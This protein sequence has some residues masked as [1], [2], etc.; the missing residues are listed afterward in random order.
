MVAITENTRIWIVLEELNKLGYI[1]EKFIEEIK[2]EF[3]KGCLRKTIREF[4]FMDHR[5]R[6]E[7]SYSL[8]IK[9]NKLLKSMETLCG[10][11]ITNPYNHFKKKQS[12][13]RL[14][15]AKI[16]D[17]LKFLQ[18]LEETKYKYKDNLRDS[19]I[20]ML[21][22]GLRTSEACRLKYSDVNKELSE[23]KIRA[24]K[25]DPAGRLLSF[26]GILPHFKKEA[27]SILLRSNK[28]EYIIF[29]DTDKI[30][31]STICH[32]LTG[33]LK[34]INKALETKIKIF[35]L[36]DLRSTYASLMFKEGAH[37]NAIANFMGHKLT[38]TTEKHYA[39]DYFEQIKINNVT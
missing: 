21:S 1:N 16:E 25:N 23:L 35:E 4:K 24:T 34:K 38:T 17:I 26:G 11:K 36:R 9:V 19:I 28:D 7:G 14:N 6:I 13:A 3:L 32:R 29:H 39:R 2:E 18:Y 33:L 37:I 15:H 8:K 5:K 20:I 10:I 22:F 12:V 30:D 27:L 31:L